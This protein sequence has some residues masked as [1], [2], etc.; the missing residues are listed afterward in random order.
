[1]IHNS[2]IKT[3]SVICFPSLLIG[4]NCELFDLGEIKT[5][6]QMHKLQNE[7]WNITY[8]QFAK[9]HPSDF[10]MWVLGPSFSIEMFVKGR[11]ICLQVIF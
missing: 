3:L 7:E 9:K 8:W 2:L 6:K 5:P 10:Q 1:M 11:G 4:N